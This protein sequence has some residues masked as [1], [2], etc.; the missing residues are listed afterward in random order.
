M[1]YPNYLIHY[2]KNHSKKNGQFISGD[3][4]GD[5]TADEHHRYSEKG[6]S[7][8]SQTK[9]GTYKE[10]YWNKNSKDLRYEQTSTTIEKKGG[11]GKKVDSLITGEQKYGKMTYVRGDYDKADELF[12][13]VGAKAASIYQETKDIDKAIKY[14]TENISDIPYKAIIS[15]TK[16][17]DEGYDHVSFSLEVY[18]DKYLY[19]TGGEPDYTDDQ[20][21]DF[22]DK[23]K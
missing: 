8:K 14:L 23:N 20:Y 10:D 4:D 11:D 13:T 5:G 2:N 3:G 19:N 15:N 12:D 21:F 16:Y 9:S 22:N 6:I 1:A 18:G 17:V 7:V